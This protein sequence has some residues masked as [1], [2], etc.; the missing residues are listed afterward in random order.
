MYNVGGLITDRRSEGFLRGPENQWVDQLR[1]LHRAHRI[2]TFILW[3][4]G[5][6]VDQTRRFAA[7]AERIR[8]DTPDAPRTGETQDASGR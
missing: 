6:V 1:W 3:P 7:V 2:D 5:D 8:G 4:E